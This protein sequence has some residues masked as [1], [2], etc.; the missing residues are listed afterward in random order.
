MPFGAS[1]HAP[2][3]RQGAALLEYVDHQR[4]TTTAYDTAIHHQH[5]RL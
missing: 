3:Q 4:H 2:R 5:E 1:A